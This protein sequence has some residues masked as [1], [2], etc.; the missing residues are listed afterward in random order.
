[1][2]KIVIILLVVICSV[3]LAA[4]GVA[5][6]QLEGASRDNYHYIMGHGAAE[7]SI[8]D[9]YCL[10]FKRLVEE[11]SSGVITVDVYSGSQLGTYGEM[12]QSLQTGDMGGMIFQPAPAVSFVPELAML[13]LPYSFYGMSQ[14]DIDYAL[15]GSDYTRILDASFQRSGY[16]RIS[17][18]QAAS[19]R[20]VTSS[21]P[22]HT[23]ADFKALNI[24][25]LENKYHIAFWKDVGANPTP[26]AFGELY[27]SLQQ[28]LVNAQ[29]NP[30]DTTLNAGF[31]EVQKY[32]VNT[33]HILYPNL[34][35]VNDALFES[36]PA[37]Y[38]E[39]FQQAA[40][41]AKDFAEAEMKDSS[42]R[43]LQNL[44]DAGLEQIDFSDEEAAKMA[45]HAQVVENMLRT[46]LGDETV[47]TFLTAIGRQ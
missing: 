16:R 31:Q 47:D 11:A 21:K 41:E 25:T 15:N 13:D 38:Q 39:I 1:M 10:E 36:M 5:A 27:L 46:D 17:I 18:A 29:E 26:V 43:D 28:G 8:G 22:I 34:F 40:D 42:V 24:R 19:F 45:A 20:E 35:I 4:G 6:V 30:Y 14:E 7:G 44:V 2:K 9:K 37:Q 23:A 32:I 12:L 3:G 33:H